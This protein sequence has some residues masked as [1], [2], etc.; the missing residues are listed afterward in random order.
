MRAHPSHVLLPAPPEKDS[1]KRLDALAAAVPDQVD[2]IILG[3]SLAAGWPAHM[4]AERLPGKVIFNFGMP[5]ERIQNT[6]WRLGTIDTSELAPRWAIILLGTN[7]LGDGDEPEEIVAGLA[8]IGDKARRLWREPR[9]LLFTIPPRRPGS[10]FR[11]SD[12][13]KTNML[14]RARWATDGCYTLIDA[15]VALGSSGSGAL[16]NDG[17]HLSPFGYDLLSRAIPSALQEGASRA[18]ADSA[19]TP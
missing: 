7:N 9:L 14:L 12:R 13:L 16:E 18:F 15:D 1:R 6:L 4:L 5:G 17:L 8:A 10:G 11:E 3:D 19:S 2:L